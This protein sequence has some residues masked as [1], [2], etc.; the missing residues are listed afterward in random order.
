MTSATARG[1]AFV[2]GHV[3]GIFAP[4]LSARDPRGRGS[5]G[6]GL[7]LGVGAHA[8]AAWVPSDRGRLSLVSDVRRPLPI[9]RDAAARLLRRRPGRLVVTVRHDLPIGQGFGMS[10]AG[11]L[12][13]SLAVARAL[14]VPVAEATATAHLADLF[15]RGGLGG[16][17]AVL[18]GGLELRRRPGIPP[19]G[20]VVHRR[21]GGGVV[22]ATVGKP[23]PSPDLLADPAFLT[24]VDRAARLGLRRLGASPTPGDFW[25][26][27]QRFT[28]A[29]RLGP[30][31]LLRL[32]AALRAEGVPAAQAM[33]GRSL[34]ASAPTDRAGERVADALARRGVRS[35]GV[36]IAR[37]G[38][39]SGTGTAPGSAPRTALG[40]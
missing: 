12:A 40:A 2:P 24:R 10:A 5:V 7:V 4:S 23:W 31:E 33:F 9:T 3:T 27:A 25:R 37:Q 18:G 15:G 34:F 13:A 30:P 26:E 36:P 22:L 38:P 6:A 32:I 20:R 29:L 39:V 21:C 14:G 11:A 17:S 19:W 28:D 8:A 1:W 16:V 35:T